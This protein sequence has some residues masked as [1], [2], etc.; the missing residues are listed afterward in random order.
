MDL[1]AEF[2]LIEAESFDD[3]RARWRRVMNV[4]PP[5][6]LSQKMMRKALIY[7]T[8]ARRQGGLSVASTRKLKRIAKRLRADPDANAFDAA[9]PTPGTRLVR[10]WRGKRYA[11]EVLNDGFAY[12]GA[13]YQSLS[14]IAHLITGAH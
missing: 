14:E 12:Q 3:L 4:D 1:S 11:V 6:G 13:V 2:E 5:S 10:D 8:Q 9:T 7:E